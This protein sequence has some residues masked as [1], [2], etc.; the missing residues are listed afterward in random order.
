MLPKKYRVTDNKAFSYIFRNGYKVR[1][2]FGMLIAYKKST[3]I[4]KDIK[5]YPKFCVV[6]NK[7]LGKATV[8]NLTRRQLSTVFLESI[9]KTIS[10][11][12]VK[13]PTEIYFEYI[14]YKPI[15]IFTE[16]Q[17]EVK[18]QIHK[19]LEVLIK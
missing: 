17:T 8:R 7:K 14:A 4:E 19:S 9:D 16:L 10:L 6:T 5:I 13:T 3:C 15:S 11:K 12:A 1:G 2:Q 18:W